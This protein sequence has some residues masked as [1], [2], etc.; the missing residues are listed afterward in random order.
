[1]APSEPQAPRSG[2]PAGAPVRCHGCRHFQVTHQPD[3]P[4]VCR[5]YGLRS[6][7][8]PSVEILAISG[9]PCQQREDRPR[10]G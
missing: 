5:A 7:R 8:L 1:M 9:Q 6:A 3:W 2:P 4:Y 10:P